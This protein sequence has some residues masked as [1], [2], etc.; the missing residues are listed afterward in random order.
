MGS[1][2]EPVRDQ[3]FQAVWTVSF[4]GNGGVGFQALK[5]AHAGISLSEAEA[6]VASP[7]TSKVCYLI[8]NNIT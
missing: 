6:S 1:Q 8:D 2:Q 4:L 5:M 7:F 3:V